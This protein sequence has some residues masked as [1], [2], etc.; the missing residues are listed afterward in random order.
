MHDPERNSPR[1]SDPSPGITL[2]RWLPVLAA[3]GLLAQLSLLGLRPALAERSRLDAAEPSVVEHH[4]QARENFEQS[5]ME[6]EAWSD[7]VYRARQAR[8]TRDAAEY[9]ATEGTPPQEEL[10]GAAS[11]QLED[12]QGS[13]RR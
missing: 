11:A 8:V 2:L 10:T 7:P 5:S 9:L 3:L 12:D 4:A 6:L 1:A 13:D